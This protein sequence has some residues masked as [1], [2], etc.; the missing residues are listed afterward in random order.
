MCTNLFAN[1][2][3]NALFRLILYLILQVYMATGKLFI[4]CI[5]I[6]VVG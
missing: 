1:T 3:C 6:A 2:S 5:L 4:G